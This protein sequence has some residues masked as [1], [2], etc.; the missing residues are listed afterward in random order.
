M[1][2]VKKI[3]KSKNDKNKKPNIFV[4]FTKYC[5]EVVAELKRVTWPSKKELVG[6]TIAVLVF[7][8]L[9]GCL[10]GALDFVFA[11]IMRLIVS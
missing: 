2:A 1:K 6:Y 9:V 4:R 3:D 11:Q 8:V 10:C 7:C 5:K